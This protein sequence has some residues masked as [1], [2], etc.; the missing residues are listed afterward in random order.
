MALGT[1]P[2]K[3]V[4][5]AKSL[6]ATNAW[7]LTVKV[8]DALGTTRLQTNVSTQV[9]GLFEICNAVRAVLYQAYAQDAGGEAAAL[10]TLIN[11]AVPFL[12]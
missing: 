6:D 1:L 3:A 9:S 11:N 7:V 5:T 8:T 2:Y 12:F 4:I 10:D